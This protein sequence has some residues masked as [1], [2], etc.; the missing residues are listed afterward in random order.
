MQT[1]NHIDAFRFAT[2]WARR[3]VSS[4]I[5]VAMTAA[6]LAVVAAPASAATTYVVQQGGSCLDTGPGTASTPFCTISA[7]ATKAVAGD[8]VRVGPG[9][10]REQVTVPSGV[11]FRATTPNAVVL[12]TDDYSAASWTPTGATAWSTTVPGAATPRQVFLGGALLTQVTGPPTT[13]GTWS[14]D[15]GTRMLSVATG[16]SV[17][18]GI[19]VTTRQ[20]GFV[21]GSPTTGITGA[22]VDGFTLGRQGGAGVYLRSGT[23][24]STIQGVTV[25][26]SASYGISD[27]GGTGNTVT[28]VHTYANA[29]IGIR[30]SNATND[31]IS[32][33]TSDDNG[34]HG[35]SVQAGSGNIVRAVVA[36]ANKKPGTRVAAGIDVSQGSVAAVVEASV[37]YGNDDSGIE[38]YT[39][40]SGAVVRR[41][42][43]YAN[44]DHGIDISRAP[45]STVISNTV[46]DNQTS[47]INVEGISTGATLRNN[48]AADN[49]RDGSRS[50]GDIRI[51]SGSEPGT[52][53]DRD[54]V[55]ES[56]GAGVVVE[57]QGV[58]YTTA[59]FASFRSISGQEATGLAADPRFV[60][61][62][63]H[64]LRLQG[65]S[66]AID[67]AD[68]T[69]TGWR[70][71]DLDGRNPVDDPKVPNFGPGTTADVGA[72]EF[73]GGVAMT[74]IVNPA[75]T[76]GLSYVVDASNSGAL[77]EAV[78]AFTVDCGAGA[79]AG[80]VNG[81]R[82][83]RCVY[84][85]SGHY[86]IR[87]TVT[88]QQVRGSS[89]SDTA[90]FPITVRENIVPT[91]V[92]TL[93]TKRI[94]PG[95]TVWA[96]ASGSTGAASYRF[97]CGRG[98]GAAQAT[99]RSRCGYPTPGTY[100]VTV[101]VVSSTGATAVASRTVTVV[102][103]VAPKARLK[104]SRHHLRRGKRV[105]ANARR[106]DGGPDTPI[107]AFKFSCGNGKRTAW[108]TSPRIACRY[109]KAGRHTIRVR[110]R[111]SIGLVDIATRIVRVRR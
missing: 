96:D 72:L 34:F 94:R 63:N 92:L 9:T 102:A 43:S 90:T 87:V 35:V 71:A 13:V 80:T 26:E 66:P 106:S 31:L 110:V 18:T 6:V 76:D 8:T 79:G 103:G 4:T 20:Y 42:I 44:G 58:N 37:A 95:E 75:S 111:N 67:R 68:T 65:S 10:Y 62:A 15:S 101:V 83:A 47:G 27:D 22:T 98:L 61:R 38:I 93:S 56:S 81:A 1:E 11:T 50:V 33:S 109:H 104:L 86:T 49:T 108:T 51:E 57:W 40:S 77:G 107:Q 32:S 25:T 39:G 3:I 84:P 64:D 89:Y 23:S 29:S 74:P 45:D 53:L 78:T 55:S 54:I 82:Q 52:T 99:P 24:G 48:I 69:A 28:G 7:A 73:R 5:V 97:D 12:G 100:T 21:L 17:P 46:V 105:W 16:G 88:G 60:G 30:L 85:A 19:D 14:W 59:T 41:N 91:A 70:N 2:Q 36:S